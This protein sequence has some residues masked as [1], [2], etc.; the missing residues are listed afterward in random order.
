MF[1][2]AGSPRTLAAAGRHNISS[3][4]WPRRFTLYGQAT[5]AHGRHMR[6]KITISG[7]RVQDVGYR[8]FL[9][10]RAS[11]LAGLSASNVG[12]DVV[13]VLAEGDSSEV[14]AFLKSVEA[15]RPPAARVS[16]IKVEDYV[17]KVTPVAEFRDTLSLEQLV[18]IAETGVEMKGDI[19]EMKGD[20]KEMLLKQDESRDEIRGL[21]TDMKS[22]MDNRFSRLESDVKLIKEKIGLA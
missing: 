2:E 19:K 16:S 20:I 17:G 18:K 5:S 13:E 9:L 12:E 4:A 21:R 15:E 11:R 10:S 1:C 8:L 7:S 3:A 22:W 6:K 14:D